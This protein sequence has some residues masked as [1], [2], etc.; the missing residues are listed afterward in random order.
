MTPFPLRLAAALVLALLPGSP[1]RAEPPPVVDLTETVDG[2]P[3]TDFAIL[4]W[5][6]A[7][8]MP[9]DQSPVRDEVGARCHVGQTGPVW[10]LAG[11]FGTSNIHRRCEIPAGRYVFFP[12]INTIVINRPDFSQPCADTRADVAR[13]TL[14]YVYLRVSLDGEEV[15]DVNRFR[16]APDACFDPFAAA[17]VTARVP[18]GG[19]AATDGFWIMLRPL[20]AGAHRLEFRAFYTNPDEALGDMVQNI[21]YDLTI[22]AE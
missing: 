9:K 10:F 5:Q 14:T 1:A 2:K 18:R 12:V 6:W 16:L 13:N 21:T 20:P 7:F 15:E 3:L 4:W 19:T 17:P 11:G 8:S 22:L